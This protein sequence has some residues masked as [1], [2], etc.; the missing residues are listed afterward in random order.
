MIRDDLACEVSRLGIEVTDGLTPRGV[1][2]TV[3]RMLGVDVTQPNSLR[4]PRR[5]DAITDEELIA[6][7]IRVASSTPRPQN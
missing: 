2:I 3:L 7:A 6:R 1:A 5:I 4:D